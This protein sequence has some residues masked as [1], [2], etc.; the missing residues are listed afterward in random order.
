MADESDL[1]TSILPLEEDN[2]DLLNESTL[3]MDCESM[4]HALAFYNNIID[5][6]ESKEFKKK[7]KKAI[8]V[9]ALAIVKIGASQNTYIAQLE[10]DSKPKPPPKKAKPALSTSK[11]QHLAVV[12]PKDVTRSSADTKEFIKKSI[13]ITQV[14]AGVKKV[15]NLRNGGILIETVSEEDLEKLLKEIENNERITE[16]YK[17]G[18][19]DK[20]NPQFICFGVS[21]ET[22]EATVAKCIKYHCGVQENSNEVKIVHSY[23][24]QRGMNWIFET[25]PGLYKQIMTMNKLNIGWERV[26]FREYLRPLRCFKCCRFGHLAKNCKEESDVCSNCGNQGHTYKDCS[27]DK[28]CRNCILHNEKARNKVDINHSCTSRLCSSYEREIKLLINKTNYE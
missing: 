13:D 26:S 27:K 3:D 8:R 6:T 14:K 24:S 20:R 12:K 5:S 16:N 28:S 10:A 22:D 4:L 15:A 7:P 9:N 25:A 19:P 18:K 2:I 17:V 21:E 11:K 23:K 1:D